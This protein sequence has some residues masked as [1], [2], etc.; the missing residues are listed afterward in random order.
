MRTTTS[1]VVLL[2]VGSGVIAGIATC[3]TIIAVDT[4]RLDEQIPEAI[5]RCWMT[6]DERAELAQARRALDE[7]AAQRRR[8]R[9][10]R[11]AQRRSRFRPDL[12][13]GPRA[14]LADMPLPQL[15]SEIQHA[16]QQGERVWAA[17]PGTGRR[18]YAAVTPWWDHLGA[19]LSEFDRRRYHPAPGQRLSRLDRVRWAAASSAVHA[20]DHFGSLSWAPITSTPQN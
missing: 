19:M 8:Q 7:Q 18:N 17:D 9:E 12:L 16:R 11:E 15:V 13:A 2:G 4:W 5:A 14:E 20:D 3:A 10:R 1:R 6:R